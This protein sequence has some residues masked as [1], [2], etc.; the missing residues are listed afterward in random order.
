MAWKAEHATNTLRAI[1]SCS[2]AQARTHFSGHF[3]DM[4]AAHPVEEYIELL[5][6]KQGGKS[7]YF[8]SQ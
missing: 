7:M 1:K 4:F 6:A 5:D 3:Q 8:S 2:R